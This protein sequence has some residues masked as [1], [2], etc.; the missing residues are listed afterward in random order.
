MGEEDGR[1]RQGEC[2]RETERDGEKVIISVL[3]WFF[4]ACCTHHQPATDSVLSVSN[5][6]LC[7][8]TTVQLREIH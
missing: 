4:T 5:L 2:E 6:F 3:A 7:A 1:E 8:H